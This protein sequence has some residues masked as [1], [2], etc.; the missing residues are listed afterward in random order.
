MGGG[1]DPVQKFGAQYG[2]RGSVPSS[3]LLPPGAKRFKFAPEP[4]WEATL[5]QR[6]LPQTRFPGADIGNE[7]SSLF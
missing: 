2:I 7:C 3:Q 1:K 5:R 6:A 4:S